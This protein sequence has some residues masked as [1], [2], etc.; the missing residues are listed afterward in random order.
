[1]RDVY[2]IEPLSPRNWERASTLG[3]VL[4]YTFGMKTLGFSSRFSV[5][6]RGSFEIR[7]GD[8]RFDRFCCDLS[9]RLRVTQ[10]A[11]LDLRIFGGWSRGEIPSQD[12]FYLYGKLEP[13]G[14]AAYIADGKG[15]F[16]TQEHVHIPGDGNM[17]GYI[18]QY[19]RGREILTMNLR[20]TVPF[21][22]LC[23]FM[24]VGALSEELSSL[25]K[26]PVLADFGLMLDLSVLRLY[27]PLW[28]SHPRCGEK[29]WG[30]RWLLELGTR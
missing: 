3:P 29:K 8:R 6:Y 22:P 7:A 12:Q 11:F 30:F 2:D 17:L 23:P 10:G 4:Q 25:D 16:G 26:V 18:N 1:M 13:K 19:R 21:L 28:V 15:S 9:S 27:F 20:L 14:I 24:D 5:G